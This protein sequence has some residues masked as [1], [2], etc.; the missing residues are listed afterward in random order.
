M[1]ERDRCGPNFRYEVVVQ[2]NST[3]STSTA[4]T[5]QA[6]NQTGIV[7]DASSMSADVTLTDLSWLTDG[8]PQLLSVRAV[9]SEGPASG[10]LQSVTVTRHPSTSIYCKCVQYSRLNKI[11]IEN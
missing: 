4:G 9:N 8:E 1:R 6:W 10:P 7:V 2:A 5:E 11:I 3:N